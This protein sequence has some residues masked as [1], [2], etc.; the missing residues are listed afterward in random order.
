MRGCIFVRGTTVVAL[1]G[2]ALTPAEET[3]TSAQIEA[4]A[5]LMADCLAGLLRTRRRVAVVHGN[6]PQVGNLAIQQDEAS[7]LVPA[8]PLH[9]LCAMTQG[10]LGSVLVR[11]IDRVRGP[12]SAVAV[13]T[14]VGVDPADEAFAAPTKPIG[15]FFSADQAALL[16]ASRRWQVVEDSGR[17]YRRVVP[18]PLPAVIVEVGAVRTLL[19]AGYVVVAAGGGGVAVSLGT[20]AAMT[21]V[22]AVIDKDHA[23]ANL[24]SELGAEELFLVTGVDTVLLDFGTPAERPVHDLTVAEVQRH[25]A[26]GQFP[27]GSMGPKLAAALRFLAAGGTRVV[28]TSAPMLAR[29]A[30]GDARVGTTVRREPV[31]VGERS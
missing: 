13:V 19:D 27:A 1:G 12:G 30:A 26:D 14:H 25:M 24:A 3:G 2:N 6:G 17:G 7:G 31:G 15:P 5:A 21:G 22:D 23:A 20:D 18:S 4:N 8:Q 11:A 9:Q 29:A 28:V 16:A 10:Q